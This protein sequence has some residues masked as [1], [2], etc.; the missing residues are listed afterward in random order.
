MISGELQ[1]RV[2]LTLKFLMGMGYTL[3]IKKGNTLQK[4]KNLKLRVIGCFS[5]NIT[6]LCIIVIRYNLI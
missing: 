4:K 6:Y 5:D 2:N 3:R 1:K